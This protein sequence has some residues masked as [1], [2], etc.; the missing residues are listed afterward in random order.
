[1]AARRGR[2]WQGC[3]KKALKLTVMVN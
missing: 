2:S 3:V 1:V